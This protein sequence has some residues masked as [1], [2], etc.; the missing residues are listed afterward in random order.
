VALLSPAIEIDGVEDP[1]LRGHVERCLHRAAHALEL[2]V[3]KLRTTTSSRELPHE[4]V[5]GVA[6]D[7][8]VM[9]QSVLEQ[10]SGLY[11]TST[12]LEEAAHLKLR[13]LGLTDGLDTFGGAFLHE[14]FANWFIFHELLQAN[15]RLVAA[16]DDGPI[17][18]GVDT[19]S[20]GYTLGAFAGAAAAGVPAATSRIDQWLARGAVEPGVRRLLGHA[21][22]LA[23][24][25]PDPVELAS[26]I[27][28]LPRDRIAPPH[29]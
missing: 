27:S 18:P 8:I 16:F 12:L 24:E 29:R 3:V 15:D 17:P 4:L 21:F 11:V 28:R 13:K 14:F 23:R 9:R 5:A 6:G 19:P 2:D 22:E 25:H 10:E 7:T 26:A 20:F 1:T